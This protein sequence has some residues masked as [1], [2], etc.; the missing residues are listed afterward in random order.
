MPRIASAS[1]NRSKVGV[2]WIKNYSEKIQCR[3]SSN[4]GSSWSSYYEWA[5][6]T[7]PDI[8]IYGNTI[9][10]VA[11]A[12]NGSDLWIAY[13]YN[14]GSSWSTYTINVPGSVDFPAVE[15]VGGWAVVYYSGG[16]VYYG[17]E[18]DPSGFTSGSFTSIVDGNYALSDRPAVIMDPTSPAW[19]I[20]AWKDSRSSTDIFGDCENGY[21]MDIKEKLSFI[22]TDNVIPTLAKSLDILKNIDKIALYNQ[23]GRKIKDWDKTKGGIYF[24]NLKKSKQ[25]KKYKII[26]IK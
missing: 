18:S 20:V 1:D 17:W 10:I 16:N 22:S 7:Y 5:G 9:M 15:Y 21:M 2:V 12:S 6:P 14:F 25:N 19:A 8:A 26:I 13:S 23:S 11:E 3:L 4:S 24:I